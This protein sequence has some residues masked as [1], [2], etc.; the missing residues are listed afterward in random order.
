MPIKGGETAL[1]N[2]GL[3]LAPCPSR[4]SILTHTITSSAAAPVGSTSI[5][6]TAETASVKI[7]AGQTLSFVAA[8]PAGR[9]EA[10]I[11]DDVTL[12]STASTVSISPL[13]QAIA[14]NSTAPFV[15]GLIPLLGLQNFSIQTQSTNVD[16]TSTYSS[17]GT[18]MALVRSSKTVQI[19]GIQIPGDV[20]LGTLVKP[21]TLNPAY[22]G[23]ELYALLVYPTGEMLAGVSKITNFQ[24]QGTQNEVLR[25]SFELNFMGITFQQTDA[26]VYS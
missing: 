2:T 14:A 15:D 16:T 13:T 25:Y 12:S 10:L 3:S 5:S 19:S 6:L 11:L 24:S 23:K 18:E 26:F 17:T 9:Q 8:T 7:Y 21:Y 22:F 1:R 20:A 4:T